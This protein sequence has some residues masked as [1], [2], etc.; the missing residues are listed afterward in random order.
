MK[1]KSLFFRATMLAIFSMPFGVQASDKQAEI[2][3]S[4]AV[5]PAAVAKNPFSPTLKRAI[6]GNGLSDSDISRSVQLGAGSQGS[7]AVLV[8]GADL[9]NS[10][11][12]D[13]DKIIAS[14]IPETSTWAMM[15]LGFIGLGFTGYRRNNGAR[16]DV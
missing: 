13:A 11:D 15:L 14:A 9:D 6:P 10:N 2:T 4:S 5:D 8:G 16:I 7:P 12:G 3:I 1:L